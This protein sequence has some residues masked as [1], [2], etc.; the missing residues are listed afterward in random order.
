M[1]EKVITTEKNQATS[2]ICLYGSNQQ[3]KEA[4]NEKHSGK[5][6][7]YYAKLE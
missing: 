6:V 2:D 7:A 1:K 5:R 3:H 4:W